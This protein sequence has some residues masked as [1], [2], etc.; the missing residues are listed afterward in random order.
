MEYRFLRYYILD[1][2]IYYNISCSFQILLFW[3]SW[4]DL[5]ILLKNQ[6]LDSLILC[7]DFT[8]FCSSFYYFFPSTGLVFGLLVLAYLLELHH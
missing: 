5:L 7:F 8:H 4:A 2:G 1:F 6:Q 3:I